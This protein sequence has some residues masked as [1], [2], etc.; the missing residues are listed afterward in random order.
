MSH[1]FL[2]VETSGLDPNR[3][4]ILEIAWVLTDRR[5]NAI[6]VPQTFLVDLE[7][8][9]WSEAWS[10]INSTKVVE[11]MHTKSGLLRD[12][13]DPYAKFTDLDTIYQ[14]LQDDVLFGNSLDGKVYLTGRSVHFDRAMLLAHNFDGLFDTD[15]SERLF[16]HRMLDLSSVK[17]MAEAAGIEV[18]EGIN[19]NPHRAMADVMGDVATARQFVLDLQ[20]VSA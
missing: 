20:K 6:G 17:I 10:R 4:K 13:N 8:A 11:D 2:D 1:I 3:D 7:D 14:K 12:I 5:F 9:D 16:H 15:G 18:E 19:M